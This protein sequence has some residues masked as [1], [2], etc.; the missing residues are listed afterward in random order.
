M[1]VNTATRRGKKARVPKPGSWEA[2]H[3]T[4]SCRVSLEELRRLDGLKALKGVDLSDI[5]RQGL[6]VM[7]RE[8]IPWWLAGFGRFAIPCS[9]CGMPLVFDLAAHPE[10]AA[11]LREAL[12]GYHHTPNCPRRES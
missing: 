4:V 7:E 8:A 3:P 12:R 5:L 11:V 10:L 2:T 1:S 9:E 6:G